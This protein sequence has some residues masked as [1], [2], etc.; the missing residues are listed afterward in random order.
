MAKSDDNTKPQQRDDGGDRTLNSGIGTHIGLDEAGRAAAIARL[1]PRNAPVTGNYADLQRM[2]ADALTDEGGDEFQL[3]PA[4]DPEAIAH[5]ATHD[6]S[7]GTI[8]VE[9]ER[10]GK[11]DDI[12]KAQEEA[13]Q[14][15]RVVDT[16][17]EVVDPGS[18]SPTVVEG[19]GDTKS[20]KTAANKIEKAKS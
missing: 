16:R 9:V 7:V 17:P 11:A 18:Q 19:T 13:A 8:T 12:R 14:E 4:Q 15:A 10:V 6:A 5:P 3:N 20:G 1:A 2:G